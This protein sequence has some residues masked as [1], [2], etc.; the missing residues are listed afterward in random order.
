[1]LLTLIVRLIYIKLGNNKSVITFY[2]KINAAISEYLLCIYMHQLCPLVC[3]CIMKNHIYI[4]LKLNTL[5]RVR[6][7]I[8]ENPNANIL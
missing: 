3:V 1:M 7:L 5:L 4:D 8:P 2:Y 6:Q